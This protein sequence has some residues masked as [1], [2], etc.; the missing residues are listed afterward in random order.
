MKDPRNTRIGDSLPTATVT[1][2]LPNTTFRVE[3]EDGKVVLVYLAGK[4]RMHRIKV[5]VGDRVKVKMDDYGVRG[6]IVQ[7]L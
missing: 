1:E 4:M 2:S 3:F 6:R 5:I 7:R